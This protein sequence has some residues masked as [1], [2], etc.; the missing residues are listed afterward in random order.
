[1]F[2]RDLV[3]F[4]PEF[5][6]VFDTGVPSWLQGYRGPLL[7]M[8]RYKKNIKQEELDQLFGGRIEAL[9]RCDSS[10]EPM[11]V[12]DARRNWLFGADRAWL[13]GIRRRSCTKLWS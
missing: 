10:F 11:L 7:E 2:S 8:M 1:M 12:A 3:C 9:L 4:H 13:A 6:H 5:R